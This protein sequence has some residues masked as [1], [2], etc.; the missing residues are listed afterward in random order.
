MARKTTKAGGRKSAGDAF[1]V[2]RV[3]P[4]H[5]D[6][7]HVLSELHARPF[8][9]EEAPRQI[10][11]FALM[12][13]SAE[14]DAHRDALQNLLSLRGLAPLPGNAR[15]HRITMSGVVIRWE[16]HTEF[17]TWSFSQTD[18]G[19]M[20]FGDP[21]PPQ[22]REVLEGLPGKLIAAVRVSLREAPGQDM[23]D[24]F[25]FGSLCV[26]RVG[27]RARVWTDMK[28][29][30]A[31]FVRFFIEATDMPPV[32]AGA[33]IQR[34]LEIETYR[35]LALLGL[36]LAHKVSGKVSRIEE[37][38]AKVTVEMQTASGLEANR[39]LL[40]T[41][42][43]L[44]TDVEALSAETS[45]RFSAVNAY[46]RIVEARLRALEESAEPDGPTIGAFLGRRLAPAMRTCE[47]IS[48]RIE[49]LSGKLSRAATLLRARVD[50]ELESQ[51]RDLLETMNRRARQQLRLQ[52]TVEGLSVAAVSYYVVGL[53]GYVAKGAEKSVPWLSSPLVTALAVPVV[54]LV[55]WMIVRRIRA[56]HSEHE[57]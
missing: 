52:Q 57:G 54:L 31:G 47:S 32:Y 29:D 4:A 3:F 1:M 34:L 42:A 14:A 10:F 39:A 45:Y 36:P 15:H 41:L 13:T 35:S 44:A 11:H 30:A 33:L 5:E 40:D 23:E 50:V 49:D 56:S 28:P 19:V 37:D 53:I 2:E 20:A 51:N 16:A 17:T 18:K 24:A 27:A 25:D 55:V 8:H 48:G 22:V 46:S 12:T 21:P 7:A 6:R 43:A 9:P 38:L 26:S